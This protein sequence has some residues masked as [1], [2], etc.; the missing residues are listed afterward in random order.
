MAG[1]L[2]G[3]LMTMDTDQVKELQFLIADGRVTI[4]CTRSDEQ[5]TIRHSSL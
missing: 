2:I 1:P 3:P 5:V 4:T